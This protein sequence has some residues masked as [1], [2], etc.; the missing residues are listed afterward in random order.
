[1]LIRGHPKDVYNYIIVGWDYSHQLHE[2]GFPPLYMEG[3]VYFHR[4]TPEAE[5]IYKQ[6]LN[7]GGEDNSEKL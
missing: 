6:L 3:N 2:L 7:E 1:M 4:R 5:K